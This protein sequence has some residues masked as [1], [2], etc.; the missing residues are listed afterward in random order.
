MSAYTYNYYMDTIHLPLSLHNAN[1]NSATHR[2]IL[3][4][5]D[6]INLINSHLIVLGG[7]S[8]GS[9]LLDRDEY[10]DDDDEGLYGLGN[11]IV[12]ICVR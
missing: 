4:S 5:N 11:I 12:F 7:I 6:V 8:V 10:P 1:S 9:I 2:L 3:E